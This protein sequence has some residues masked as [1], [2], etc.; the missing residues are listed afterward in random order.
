M[1]KKEQSPKWEP[2]FCSVIC[3]QDDKKCC[4]KLKY[5]KNCIINE[6]MLHSIFEIIQMFLTRIS[7]SV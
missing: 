6:S 1:H 4:K 3:D 5:I 2:R 7:I